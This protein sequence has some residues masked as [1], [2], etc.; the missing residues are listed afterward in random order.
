MRRILTILPTKRVLESRK[1]GE[2]EVESEQ[3]G[4]TDWC[5]P[6]FIS[7]SEFYP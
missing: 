7:L 4:N 3:L 1:N 2:V 6:L 5:A